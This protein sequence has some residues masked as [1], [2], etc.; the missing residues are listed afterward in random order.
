MAFPYKVGQRVC[1]LRLVEGVGTCLFNGTVARIEPRSD[2]W[3][4]VFVRLD[5]YDDEK[6]YLTS[7][8]GTSDS[9]EPEPFEPPP[10]GA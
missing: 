5:G 9:L 7:P 3:V 8:R 10:Q 1:G 6:R 2:L 4:Y